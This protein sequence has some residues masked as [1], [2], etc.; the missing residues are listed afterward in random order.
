MYRQYA[1]V[2]QIHQNSRLICSN[3]FRHFPDL[4]LHIMHALQFLKSLIL[5]GP[6]KVTL[7][8]DVR[9]ARPIKVFQEGDSDAMLKQEL[10]FKRIH[11]WISSGSQSNCHRID[12]N[13]L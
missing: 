3:I 4:L 8:F 11:P 10:N 6:Q 2:L 9:K 5:I 13:V 12:D 7:D 1:T